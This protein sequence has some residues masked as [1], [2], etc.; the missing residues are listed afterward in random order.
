MGS[1]VL[2]QHKHVT[3]NKLLEIIKRIL[4]KIPLRENIWVSC[5]SFFEAHVSIK[6]TTLQC[7]AFSFFL[8]AKKLGCFLKHY[9]FKTWLHGEKCWCFC[10]F[11]TSSQFQTR[12]SWD[13]TSLFSQK[14]ETIVMLAQPVSVNS[15]GLSIPVKKWGKRLELHCWVTLQAQRVADTRVGETI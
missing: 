7:N 4:H 2:F 15:Q 9:A 5:T 13:E 8:A 6:K 3:L 10:V 11:T 1:Y 14:C 12:M